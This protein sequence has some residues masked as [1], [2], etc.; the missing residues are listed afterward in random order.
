MHRITAYLTLAV[1]FIVVISVLYVPILFTLKKK[2]KSIL[3]QLS[4]LALFCSFFLIIFATLLFTEIN[5][6]PEQYVLNLTPFKWVEEVNSNGIDRVIVEVVPNIIMFIPLGSFLPVVFKMMRKLYR[7]FFIIFLVT[8]SV[9]FLQYFIGRSSDIDD[10]I[11]NILGGIIGY[12]IFKIFDCL[13][14]NT[15]WW[16][17]F[18]T[19]R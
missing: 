8:F 5:F 15:G 12:G 9:E 13:F 4:Y 10:M 7:A 17:N 18:I 11:A 19:Q 2:G 16:N 3:R 1:I 6:R 14:K